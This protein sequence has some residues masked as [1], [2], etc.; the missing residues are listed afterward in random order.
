MAVAPILYHIGKSDFQ[1]AQMYFNR[2]K[3]QLNYMNGCWHY[4][5][6]PRPVAPNIIGFT[7]EPF[8]RKSVILRK[9]FHEAA[10]GC[11]LS[12]EHL[13]GWDYSAAEAGGYSAN[14][15]VN[16]FQEISPASPTRIVDSRLCFPIK[17]ESEIVA[18]SLQTRFLGRFADEL[19]RLVLASKS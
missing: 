5:D 3:E 17:T 13:G 10:H 19:E 11:E 8:L 6:K 7:M 9:A 2:G 4:S 1:I 14:P 15:I 12:V 18:K 16:L